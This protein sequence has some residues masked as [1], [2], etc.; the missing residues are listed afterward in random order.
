MCACELPNPLLI[1]CS[2]RKVSCAIGWHNVENYWDFEI[3]WVTSNSQD[4][5]IDEMKVVVSSAHYENKHKSYIWFIFVYHGIHRI[6]WDFIFVPFFVA[7]MMSK[8]SLA[9][10][11]VT[12]IWFQNISWNITSP[13][14]SL[15]YNLLS[16]CKHDVSIK[17]F[18]LGFNY[19]KC[20]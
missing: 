8:G 11:F 10:N 12:N 15:K 4:C 5:T 18:S 20:C 16:S 6:G 19:V 9:C 2:W 14:Q 17:Y 1:G 13:C 3:T 7:P